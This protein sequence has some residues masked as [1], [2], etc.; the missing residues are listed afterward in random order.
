MSLLEELQSIDLSGIA[1]AR[2]SISAAVSGPE[3]QALLNDG[4]AQ[5]A[6]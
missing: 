1:N 2:G 3:L 6:G 4:A 5:T